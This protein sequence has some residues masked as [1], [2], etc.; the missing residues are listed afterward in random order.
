MI[1][2]KVA[3]VTWT[4]TECCD[5]WPMYFGRMEK[6]ANFNNSYVLLNNET[7]LINN[8]HK[9]IINNEKDK[10]YKRIVDSLKQIKEEYFLYLQED[11]IFYKSVNS[12]KINNLLNIIEKDNISNIRL[13]KSGELN[14]FTKYKNIYIIPD[15]SKYLFSQ[16]SSIWNKKKFIQLMNFYKPSNYRD[17]EQ[18]GSIAMNNLGFKTY[19]YYENEPKRGTLHFDS[20]IFPYIATAVCKKKWNLN[21]YPIL[22]KEAL[23]EYQIDFKKRGVYEY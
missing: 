16:Q 3:M 7:D 4:N 17:V 10:F 21:Q 13:L 12:K 20:N 5:I 2:E 8:K 18:F 23:I 11:H 1:S 9:Q 14:G 22:L 19:Y 15:Y 6:H